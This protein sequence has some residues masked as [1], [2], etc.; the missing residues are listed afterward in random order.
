M[1][2]RSIPHG[3]VALE[4][5]SDLIPLTYQENETLKFLQ[6]DICELVQ[7]YPC[8]TERYDPDADLSNIPPPLSGGLINDNVGPTLQVDISKPNYHRLVGK[9]LSLYPILYRSFIVCYCTVP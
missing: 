3:K 1:R 8:Q 6:L 2:I 4:T 5:G 9:K 7:K